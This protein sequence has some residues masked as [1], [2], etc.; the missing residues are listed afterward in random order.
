MN[1][2]LRAHL[3]DRWELKGLKD[4]ELA[5]EALLALHSGTSTIGGG[6]EISLILTRSPLAS[7]LA[8][9]HRRQI[10][11]LPIYVIQ[12]PNMLFLVAAST[13]GLG[14]GFSDIALRPGAEVTVW[15]RRKPLPVELLDV[16][17]AFEVLGDR[18]DRMAGRL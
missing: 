2:L 8:T 15:R 4:E 7:L 6:R 10:G 9:P 1:T 13:G 18:V 11:D 3:S 12:L 5:Q 17:N 16:A 14:P